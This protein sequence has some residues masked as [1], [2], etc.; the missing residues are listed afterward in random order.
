MAD[1][2]AAAHAGG[3]IHRDLKPSN[4]MV[5]PE[6]R[7]K[8]LDFGL[9]KLLEPADASPGLSTVTGPLTVAQTLL[10][11]AAYMSPEQA[12]GRP[13][14]ARSDIFS[15]G[16]MLYDMVAGARPF[17]GDSQV[18]LLGRILS[19]EP[20]PP[21]VAVPSIPPDLEKTIIRCLRKDPARRYQTMADLRVALEDLQV[22]STSTTAR[23]APR[24]QP[25]RRV[26]SVW[27]AALAVPALYMAWRVSRPLVQTE[28]MHADALTTLPGAELYPA[29][30]PDGDRVAFTWT[31]PRQDNTDI[32]VQQIGAGDPLRLTTDPQSDSSPIW[33][34]DGRWIAFLRGNPPRS[35]APSTRELRLVAPAGRNAR[36]PTYASRRIRSMRP[37]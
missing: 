11:T 26:A 15:F 10:G 34:P 6:R 35:L 33:S 22:E 8:I 37:S 1:A 2:L 32:Y 23:P 28:P 21:S 19:Q 29:L 4:V 13:V 5:L 12:E 24:P 7:I 30:S 17:A 25:R 16:I 36:L 9:A 3:I 18:A 31:G 27:V 20:T 14:D